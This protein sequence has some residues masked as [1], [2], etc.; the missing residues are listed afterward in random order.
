MFIKM[1]NEGFNNKYIKPFEESKKKYLKEDFNPN[2][3]SI[4]DK[5]T[6]LG[7][8]KS[9]CDY[10][11][12][13]NMGEEGFKFLWAGNPVEQIHFMRTIYNFLI[14]NG[15][16]VK[17]ISEEDIDNY[18]N[19]FNQVTEQT[20]ESNE[21]LKESNYKL[22]EDFNENNLN[23]LGTNEYEA[24][25]N[26]NKHVKMYRK[27]ANL[28]EEEEITEDNINEVALNKTACYANREPERIKA[29][30]LGRRYSDYEA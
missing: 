2:Q 24:N 16:D 7:R 5:Y 23:K 15:V 30:I 6:F 9:D 17:F 3:L 19:Y 10:I 11:I 12:K 18:E 14:N 20:V 26:R 13:H 1:I 8:L 4:N 21:C 28:N 22:S 27:Y 25:T 29:E